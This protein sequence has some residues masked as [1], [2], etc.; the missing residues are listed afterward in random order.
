MMQAWMIRALSAAEPD[1]LS[2]K[3]AR[4]IAYTL[5]INVLPPVALLRTAATSSVSAKKL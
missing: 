2:Y 3:H 5:Y 1:R 4:M